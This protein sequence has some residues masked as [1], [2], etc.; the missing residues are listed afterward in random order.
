[1]VLGIEPSMFL[2]RMGKSLNI[3]G[4]A[5]CDHAGI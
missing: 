4:S 1:M 5:D 2:E 3:I